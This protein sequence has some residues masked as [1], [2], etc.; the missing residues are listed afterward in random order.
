MSA[1]KG[2]IHLCPKC[3]KIR[4]YNHAHDSFY[5]EDCDT[6]LELACDDPTCIF[7]YDRKPHPSNHGLC[8][9]KT[10]NQR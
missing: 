6:W 7:C 2:K 3:G 9:S 5:C 8:K 1:T 4:A 10:K